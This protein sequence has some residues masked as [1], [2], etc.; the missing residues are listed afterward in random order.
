MSMENPQLAQL[1]G[2]IV[3][4]A[5]TPGYTVIPAPTPLTFLN[6]YDGKFLRA[7]DLRQEQQAQR[8]LVELSNRAG[9]FGVAYG[10]DVARGSSGDTL[11]L[12]PGLGGFVT[13]VLKSN[14]FAARVAG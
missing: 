9:G 7:A 4:P 1:T 3:L 10:L 2:P 11:V 5:A 14:E 12:G 8:A 13:A 6:Y